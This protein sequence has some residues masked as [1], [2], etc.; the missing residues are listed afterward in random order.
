M[1][2]ETRYYNVTHNATRHLETTSIG[3]GSGS[4]AMS[5]DTFTPSVFVTNTTMDN[6]WRLRGAVIGETYLVSVIPINP[7]GKGTAANLTF[8]KTFNQF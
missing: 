6:F 7:L 8:S 3:S 1:R 2:P 4:G 5:D